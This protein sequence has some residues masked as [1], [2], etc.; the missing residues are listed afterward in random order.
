MAWQWGE[1]ISGHTGKLK[2]R[3][4]G[5]AAAG[6]FTYVL[7]YISKNLIENY[8][9]LGLPLEAVLLTA[10]QKGAISFVNAI[11]SILVAVPLGLVLRPVLLR[12]FD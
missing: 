6:A 4:F 1:I 7:L 3:F 11:V 5:G 9:V 8:Y 2:I 10:A 12:H